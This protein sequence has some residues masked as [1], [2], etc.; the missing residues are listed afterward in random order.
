MNLAEI[1]IGGAMAKNSALSS[2]VSHVPFFGALTGNGGSIPFWTRLLEA[3]IIAGVTMY[4]TVQI[5][6]VKIDDLKSEV[7]EVKADVRAIQQ[8]MIVARREH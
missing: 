3:A 8:A 4:G 5:Q 2:V 1:F 6:G 7:A